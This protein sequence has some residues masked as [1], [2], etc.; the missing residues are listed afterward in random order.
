MK[1]I[2]VVGQDGNPLRDFLLQWSLAYSQKSSVTL[3]L[4]GE[5]HLFPIG[6]CAETHL[7]LNNLTVTH[8]PDCLGESSE[9]LITNNPVTDADLVLVFVE[10]HIN[11][12][13]VVKTKLDSL[14]GEMDGQVFWDFQSS[15]YDERYWRKGLCVECAHKG[16]LKDFE[17]V[18]SD[19]DR[20]N[21]LK[22]QIFNQPDIQHLS[23]GHRK[24]LDALVKWADEMLSQREV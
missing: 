8:C 20:T 2:Y 19:R 10:Q 6:E 12:W 23:K 4:H 13:G 18:L 3:L 11:A 22:A 1:R 9:V 15:R 24:Q 5:Q 14:Q 17:F 21:W 16:Q 7:F